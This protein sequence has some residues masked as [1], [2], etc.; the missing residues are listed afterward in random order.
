MNP[1][2]KQ[3]VLILVALMAGMAPLLAN[4]NFI[5]N[6]GNNADLGPAAGTYAPGATIT[7]DIRL[8]FPS[9][10]PSDVFAVSYWFESRQGGVLLP[11]AFSITSRTFGASPFT[12]PQTPGIVFPQALSGANAENGNDLGNGGA[13]IAAPANPFIGTITFTIAGTVAPGTYTLQSTTASPNNGKASVVFNQAGDQGF[14]LPAA[15]Y[16]VTVVPEP[17]TWMFVVLAGAGVFMWKRRHLV[18]AAGM[19]SLFFAQASTAQ[20]PYSIDDG[21][22]EFLGA[23]QGDLIAL[24]SFPVTP[25]F[26][27]ITSISIAFSFPGN[28]RPN[29]DGLSFTAVLWSDPNGDGSPTDA[30]VLTTAG[31]V[32]SGYATNTFVTVNIAPTL[33]LT[34]NF[35]VGFILTA[36]SGTSPL[37][38]DQEDPTLADRSFLAA[39]TA[40]S[41]DI[42]NLNNNNV[43]PVA[44]V[45]SLGLS[46][47]WLIRADAVPEPS[48]YLLLGLGLAGLILSRRG[49]RV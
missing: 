46:G 9:V 10:P 36:P 8:N 34:P 26:E 18:C 6:D 2:K 13:V 3:T 16:T 4:A 47:N 20:T 41:G 39:S 11:G 14:D 48:T 22:A 15:V 17:A 28:V 21:T 5:F 27:A 12:D 29:L 43:I 30:V 40:G 25:G 42:N 35:F 23:S 19:L 49:K 44:S 32:I 31:G 1:M 45:D 37:A 24:N 33:V 38:F 7:F